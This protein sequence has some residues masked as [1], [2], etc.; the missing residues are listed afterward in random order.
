MGLDPP[1]LVE[2]AS[3]PS[4]ARGLRGVDQL[5][6][7]RDPSLSGL[8]HCYSDPLSGFVIWLYFPSFNRKILAGRSIHTSQMEGVYAAVVSSPRRAHIDPTRSSLN[9]ASMR[10]E[11]NEGSEHSTQSALAD[12]CSPA[13]RVRAGDEADGP[14]NHAPS[15]EISK[16]RERA[17]YDRIA[18]YI[19]EFR[20]SLRIQVPDAFYELC[21]EELRSFREASKLSPQFVLKQLKIV[22]NQVEFKFISSGCNSSYE[23]LQSNAYNY[24]NRF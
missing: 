8:L 13:L 11:M 20:T 10:A 15:P 22:K 24:L 21:M 9:S 18:E 6:S 2:A 16:E 17:M 4:V 12:I 19:E 5:D 14:S 7:A 23:L 1:P 3:S